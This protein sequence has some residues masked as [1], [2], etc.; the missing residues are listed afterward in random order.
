MTVSEWA[1]GHRILDRKASALPR[2]WRT[3]RPPYLREPMD[4]FKTRHIDKI[5]LCFGTQ[6]G[7]SEAILNMIG[8]AV[9][10]DPGSTLVVYPID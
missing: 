4:A 5:T 7:K 6:L 10:Q 8:Y 2:P 3:Y 1:D 9:D